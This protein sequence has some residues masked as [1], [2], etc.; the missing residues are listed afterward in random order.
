MPVAGHEHGE[1]A[2][3]PRGEKG[4]DGLHDRVTAPYSQG[5]TGQEVVLGV[6]D[7]GRV[8]GAWGLHA[9]A[10]TRGEFGCRPKISD[11]CTLASSVVNPCGQYLFSGSGAARQ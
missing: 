3:A 9:F 11:Q 7:E 10:A 8:A 1:P 4:V 2:L 6:D 5:T